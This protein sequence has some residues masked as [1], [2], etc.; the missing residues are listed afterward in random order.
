MRAKL[1]IELKSDAA[2]ASGIGKGLAVDLDVCTDSL[3]YPYIPA[4]RIKGLIK[5]SAREINNQEYFN[6][7]FGKE[8]A[9]GIAN[10]S[11]SA[12]LIIKDAVIKHKDTSEPSNIIKDKYVSLRTFTSID[13]TT[14]EV[15][16]GSLRTINVVNKGTE[17]ESILEFDEKY[18]QFLIEAISLVHH[19]GVHRNRGLGYVK[20][21]LQEIDNKIH[22]L[23]PLGKKTSTVELHIT[24]LDNLMIN[25]AIKDRSL[26]YI[27][28]STIYGYFAN[29]YAKTKNFNQK[30]FDRLFLN[31]NE[32]LRFSNA[33]ISDEDYNTY[34]PVPSY[35]RR[36]KNK[37]KD[38]STI[39]VNN[40]VKTENQNNRKT[41]SL[42]GKYIKEETL[43]YV[44]RHKGDFKNIEIIEPE[45]EYNYHLY[46]TIGNRT[47]LGKFYQF[48]SLTKGQHFVCR[49][50]G[51]QE[52]LDEL[53]S[54]C[55]SKEIYL[56]KSKYN[57]YGKCIISAKYVETKKNNMGNLV[58]FKSESLFKNEGFPIL[59]QQDIIKQI[60][61]N[62]VNSFSIN[63]KNIG[64]YNMLRNLP[65][66]IETVVTP[67]SYILFK[68]LTKVNA[69]S[70]DLFKG[71]GEFTIFNVDLNNLED[72]INKEVKVS[73][74][75]NN[76]KSRE[77][78]ILEASY[79][80]FIQN[81]NIDLGMTEIS[82]IISLSSDKLIT[83]YEGPNS[84]KSNIE[85]IKKESLKGK[86]NE[87]L[88]SFENSISKFTDLEKIRAVRELF[89]LYK[90]SKR[91]RK[92]EDNA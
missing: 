14:G 33:Y 92:D 9:C 49:I 31:N 58:I 72:A 65:R 13:Q 17:F 36:V 3:G 81:S 7:L 67:G 15:K 25:G 45:F 4:R 46:K 59:N 85:L 37:D 87:I 79:N 48:Y 60:S 62:D 43:E 66:N 55:N 5:D 77:V 20:M 90:Y 21:T 69:I 76:I 75:P 89:T 83:K 28:G 74:T 11:T 1:I 51:K 50:T 12:N 63:F 32:G 61:N 57:Q 30:V 47:D 27:P 39:Y 56:G 70:C 34:L 54:K 52:D 73:S 42:D 53:F 38:G 35:I 88:K 78:R 86:I 23:L 24:N 91:E 8:L 6:N 44:T 82:K 29:A 10:S 64:G 16:D 80:F 71:F 19:L 22:M 18:L 40:L 26:D 84:F 2:I 41:E 68:S